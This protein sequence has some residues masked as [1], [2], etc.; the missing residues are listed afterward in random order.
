MKHKLVSFIII[1]VLFVSPAWAATYYVKSGGNDSL[2]GLSDGTAWATIAKVQATVTSGDTVYFRS[3]DTWSSSSNPV[4]NATAG[5][6]YDGST[7]GSGTRA[8]LQP[9]A[10]MD[11]VVKISVSNVV[12]K[13]FNIDMNSQITGGIGAGSY[14]TSNVS[15]ITIDNCLVHDSIMP[16]GHWGYGIHTGGYAADNVTVDSVT[17]TNTQVYNTGHEG[18]AIYPSWARVNAKATNVLV[19]NCIIH[20]TGWDALY[21]VNNADNLTIEFNTIYNSSGNGIDIGTSAYDNMGSVNNLIVRYNLIYDN[22]SSGI[23]LNFCSPTD[24]WAADGVFYGNIIMNSGSSAGGVGWSLDISVERSYRNISD[25]GNY[26]SS[27][28]SFYNNT[29]FNTTNAAAGKG[30]VMVAQF[31]ALGGTPTINFKNNIVYTSAFTP[32]RDIRNL[33]THSNNLIFRTDNAANEHVNDGTSRNRAGV[34]TWEASAQ[35]TDPTFTG[36]TLPTGFTGTYGNNLVPNTN[37]FV[38]TSGDAL[39]NGATLGSPYNGSINGAGRATPIT[40]PQGA[41]YDIGAY[42]YGR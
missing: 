37:Y 40:R 33:L 24:A 14:A 27:T 34:K 9:T 18:I 41:A 39:N 25:P 8:T 32:V 35:N 23:A 4:L 28:F 20:D 2:D 12:F 36:G 26:G 29:I 1:L 15:N 5:V 42:E 6:T 10:T 7:Y 19:R 3:Q 22:K 16:A 13:G 17:I 11:Y 21:I 38:I 30:G 31:A